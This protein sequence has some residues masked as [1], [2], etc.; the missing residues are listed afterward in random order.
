M[1]GRKGRIAV[2]GREGREAECGMDRKGDFARIN[3]S[4]RCGVQISVLEAT[5]EDDRKGG[6][7]DSKDGCGR[8]G[9]MGDEGNRSSKGH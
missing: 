9:W 2:E 8:Q 1:K 3:F 4:C 6:R 5:E 7:E